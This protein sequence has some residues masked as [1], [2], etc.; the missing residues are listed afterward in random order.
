L[1]PHFFWNFLLISGQFS[2]IKGRIPTLWKVLMADDPIQPDRD[3]VSPDASKIDPSNSGEESQTL[4]GRISRRS[5]LSHLGA[6]GIAA[7]AQPLLAATQS[8]PAPA[9]EEAASVPGAIPIALHVNGKEHRLQIE[10]R[11]TLL[12]FLR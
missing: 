5:F 8:P 9:S 2:A 7:T 4:F 11:V 6:A 3:Q 10:P 12:D 1:P